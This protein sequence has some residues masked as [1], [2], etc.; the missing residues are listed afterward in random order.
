MKKLLPLLLILTLLFTACASDTPDE[1]IYEPTEEV[2]AA[3]V[4]NTE[5]V[6]TQAQPGSTFPQYDVVRVV[7]GD[8]IVIDFDGTNEKVRLI[9]VDTPESVH[10][11]KEKNSAFGQEVSEFSKSQLSGKSVGIEFDVRERD[12]YGRLLAYVYLGDEMYNKK[13]L[14]IGYASVATFP[15]NVKYVDEFTEIQKKA[16]ENGIG[17]WAGGFIA[18]EPSSGSSSDSSNSDTTKNTSSGKYNGHIKNKKFHL[19]GC[20]YGDMISYENLIVFKTRDAAINEGY[21]P[22]KVCNP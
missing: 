17:M 11:D 15:P 9:G 18:G 10:P 21:A 20:R 19:P 6:D 8:T 14:E 7:D 5:T 4:E 1:A 12:Q 13:L 22:C 16:R 3:D 2:G